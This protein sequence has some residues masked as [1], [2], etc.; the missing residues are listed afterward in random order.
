MFKGFSNRQGFNGVPNNSFGWSQFSAYG[1]DKLNH[2]LAAE[3]LAHLN[4][5]DPI[6]SWVERCKKIVFTE[7]TAGNQ[8]RFIPSNPIFNN[9]PT[10]EFF[11]TSRRLASNFFMGTESYFTIAIVANCNTIINAGNFLMGVDGAL[12]Q[13]VLGGLNA[14]FTGVWVGYTGFNVLSGTTES[15]SPRIILITRS[16]IMVN[17]VIEVSSATPIQPLAFNRIGQRDNTTLVALNG[18]IAEIL[19]YNKEFSDSDLLVL[20]NNLNSKYAIY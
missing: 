12:P 17:T 19:I 18:N 7:A 16:K 3:D 11:T 14:L 1:F 6:S 8:P 4:L 20:S 15:T 13:I 10:V 5:N 9:L 2:W